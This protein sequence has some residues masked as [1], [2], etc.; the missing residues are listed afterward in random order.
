MSSAIKLF[1]FG[2]VKKI[3]I[4]ERVKKMVLTLRKKLH[5]ETDSNKK[6]I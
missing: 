3:L 1:Q 2:R 4:L 5:R 6:K